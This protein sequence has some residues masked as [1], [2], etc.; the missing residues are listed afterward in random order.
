V[1][2]LSQIAERE[3]ERICVTLWE[4]CRALNGL[5]I[6]NSVF[7]VRER[8]IATERPPLEGKVSANFCGYKGVPWGQRGGS[9]WPYSRLS[10]PEPLLFLSSSSSVVLTR[11]S[12]PRS[13]PTTSQKNVV[14]PGNR[15]RTSGSV[16]RD[17]D[18]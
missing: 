6:N 9:L 1:E 16:G 14:A 15:T 8:T 3:R 10:I 11:L 12:G 4:F 18:H 7:L 2:M 5:L 13:R 17:S